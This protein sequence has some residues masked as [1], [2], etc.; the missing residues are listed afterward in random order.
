[1]NFGTLKAITI[2]EGNVTMITCGEVVLWA[3]NSFPS[4]PTEY[5]LIET[6]TTNYTFIAPED[7]W[8]KIEVFGA[9]GSGGNAKVY[10]DGDFGSGYFVYT[11]GGGGGGAYASSIIK[12]K[13]GDSVNISSLS[14][15]DTAS[16]SINSSIETYTTINVTSGKNG[17]NAT[18]YSYGQGGSGGTASGGQTNKNGS[19]GTSGDLGADTA[20]EKVD[21]GVG[22]ASAH[23]DGN[24]G[25]SAADA[26]YRV[27]GSPE[28]GKPAFVKIYRGNTNVVS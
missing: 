10:Y 8:Y 7:G 27:P 5:K 15:G 13:A 9:S 25:G 11:G 18:T 28:S 20:T 22:G 12:L 4:E 2:P 23:V 21:G 24:K 16:V 6:Y 3:I 14:V 19:S 17:T 26:S 1:M